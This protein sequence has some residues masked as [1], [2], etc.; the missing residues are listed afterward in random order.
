MP[1][2]RVFA[3][4]FFLVGKEIGPGD[5]ALYQHR[6]AGAFPSDHVRR[7]AAGAGLFRKDD[8]TAVSAAKPLFGLPYKLL[9]GHPLML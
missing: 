8:A 7:F 3:K 5:F 2:F 9:V 4:G 1:R 6:A